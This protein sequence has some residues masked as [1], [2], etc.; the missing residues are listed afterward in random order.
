MCFNNKAGVKDGI[1]DNILQVIWII[2]IAMIDFLDWLKENGKKWGI[3]IEKYLP[4]DYII[5]EMNNLISF[6]K[7]GTDFMFP[8]AAP[9]LDLSTIS[10]LN[11]GYQ[12]IG[13]LGDPT[14][15]S[16]I[17]RIV[18]R[19]EDAAKVAR[20]KNLVSIDFQSEV[21]D[22]LLLQ[23]SKH[24]RTDYKIIMNQ[25]VKFLEGERGIKIFLTAESIDAKEW[26]M[27]K[28]KRGYSYNSIK[29]DKAALS[30]FYSYLIQSYPFV[31]NIFKGVKLPKSGYV[32][33][34]HVPTEEEIAV[35]IDSIE[36]PKFKVI[37]KLIARYGYRVGFGEDAYFK[38][39]NTIHFHSKGKKWD[40]VISEEE[41]GIL[42][43][44][45]FKVNISLNYGGNTVSKRF[46]RHTENLVK[47]GRVSYNYGAHS[48]RHAYAVRRFK[49]TK[50]IRTVMNELGHSSI[51]ITEKYLRSLDINPDITAV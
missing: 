6:I 43:Q 12:S 36:D 37:V 39:D 21:D 2:I 32:K 30:A 24:T 47:E 15:L 34:L 11:V 9:S 19:N 25:W 49:E 8:P 45:G 35:I 27:N 28:L 5:Y 1:K 46:L 31:V 44:A 10:L 48:F 14:Y 18:K 38:D 3:S 23:N 20:Y 16:E 51:V 26:I 4:D 13:G 7:G 50:N 29:A 40:R 42:L 22:W 41:K 33:D 17:A